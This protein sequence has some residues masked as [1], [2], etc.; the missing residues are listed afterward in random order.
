MTTSKVTLRA[1][2]RDDA[3]ACASMA[4]ASAIGVRYGFTVQALTESLE[5]GLQAGSDLFVAENDGKVAGF[6]WVDPRGAFSTAPYLRLI[7]VDESLRG[8]GI[9]SALLAEF[10]SR[11]A[12]VGRD[13]C[14][15]VSDFNTQAQAFYQRHGYRRAGALPDFA[16]PGIAE[17]LM[18]KKRGPHAGQGDA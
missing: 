14:L 17:I 12:S 18:I 3:T 2:S 13:W 16:R 8:T 15:L 7:V 4:C 6:A 5:A 11:T 9:G 1:M 10:E